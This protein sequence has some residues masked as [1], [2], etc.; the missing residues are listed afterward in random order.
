MN[1]AMMMGYEQVYANDFC[2]LGYNSEEDEITLYNEQGEVVHRS[3]EVLDAG[4]LGV[5]RG[6][7]IKKSDFR[8]AWAMALITGIETNSRKIAWD[9]KVGRLTRDYYSDFYAPSWD[10]YVP[11]KVDRVGQYIINWG[12]SLKNE[13]KCFQAEFDLFERGCGE[14]KKYLILDHGFF[15]KEYGVRRDKLTQFDLDACYIDVVGDKIIFNYMM[16]FQSSGGS[17]KKRSVCMVRRVLIGEARANIRPRLLEH[18]MYNEF[19]IKK[20]RSMDEVKG[21]ML[22]EYCILE[23]V[24]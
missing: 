17:L 9:M 3:F 6:L 23:R 2:T 11:K 10:C 22:K 8:T 18:S 5:S 7:Y 4:M 1:I 21:D 12:I 20:F 13:G 16:F 24:K 14:S 19:G 15:R